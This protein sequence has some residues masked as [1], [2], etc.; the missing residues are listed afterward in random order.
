MAVFSL[1][2][3]VFVIAAGTLPV[4]VAVLVVFVIGTP[5][6]RWLRWVVVFLYVA[7]GVSVG[8][9][10]GTSAGAVDGDLRGH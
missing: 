8:V 10:Y 6:S 7:V 9:G 1:F 3:H 4:A 2:G 5:F